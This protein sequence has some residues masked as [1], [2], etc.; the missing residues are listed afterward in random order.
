MK[1]ILSGLRADG[2][3]GHHYGTV[4]RFCARLLV[5]FGYF[6]HFLQAI[7]YKT[8]DL[9]R[10]WI[11]FTGRAGGLERIA[12]VMSSCNDLLLAVGGYKA[13]IES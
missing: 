2:E 10:P 5:V 12:E 7:F 1:R 9:R 13:Y 3:E 8:N 11:P 4:P 6:R